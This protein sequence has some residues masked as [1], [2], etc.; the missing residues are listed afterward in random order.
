[1]LCELSLSKTIKKKAGTYLGSLN[2]ELRISVQMY[3]FLQK[4]IS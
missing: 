3:F 4:E 1:M 2:Y